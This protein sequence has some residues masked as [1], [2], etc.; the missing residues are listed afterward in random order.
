MEIKL[1]EETGGHV[2]HEKRNP[3]ITAII[4]MMPLFGCSLFILIL[5]YFFS[6]IGVV[7]ST[8]RFSLSSLDFLGTFSNFL[9]IAG[10]SFYNNIITYDAVIIVFFILF[11]YFVGSVAACIAPSTVDLKHAFLGMIIIALLGLITIYLHPLGYVPGVIDNFGTSTP[12]LDFI[13]INL[14]SAIGI[15][16]IGVF[17][18]L[19]ILI[20]IAILKNR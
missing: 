14:A 4:A 18:I 3:F 19:L 1:F 10:E 2:T 15:G 7:F 6:Q 11:L 9:L 16:M 5:A 13:V 20:P 8:T 17:L 12:V